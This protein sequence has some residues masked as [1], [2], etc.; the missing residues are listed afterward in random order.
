V[1]I[2]LFSSLDENDALFANVFMPHKS[3]FLCNILHK[4]YFANLLCLKNMNCIGGGNVVTNKTTSNETL[5]FGVNYLH[6]YVNHHLQRIL[7][8]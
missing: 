2:L 4:N 6:S 8:A 3:V 7:S 1:A 5:H